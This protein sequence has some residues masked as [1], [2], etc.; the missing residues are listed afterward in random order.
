M[1]ITTTGII[2]YTRNYLETVEFYK[3]I[4]DLKTLYVKNNLTCLDFNGGYLMIELDDEENLIS[5]DSSS[6]NKF[7]VRFNVPN[8]KSACL[9][10]DQ[11]KIPYAYYENDWGQVAKF[12]DPDNNQVGIRSAKEHEDDIG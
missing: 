7:C 3:N 6:R 8:V 10:L 1:E 12:T 9:K 5:E 4:F 11:E 2:L